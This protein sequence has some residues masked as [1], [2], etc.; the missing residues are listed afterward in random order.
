MSVMKQWQYAVNQ[1]LNATKKNFRKALIL[2]TAHDA[3]LLK[4]MT[5][6][7]GDPDWALLYNRYHPKHIAYRLAYNNWVASGGS[8]SGD[9]LSLTELFK[10][11]PAKLDK[12]IGMIIIVYAKAS[13]QY[14]KLFPQ[15]RK[16][17]EQGKTDVRISAIETLS[18]SIGA[19][20]A[21][22]PVKTLVDAAYVEIDT[23]RTTQGGGKSTK[24]ANSE[25]V[26]EARSAVMIMQY[27]DMGF[28][29]N[30]YPATPNVIVSLFDLQ[31]LRN[32]VQS[33][34]THK[35]KP[36]ENCQLCVNT[37]KATDAIRAKFADAGNLTDQ[38]TIYL[39]STPGGIDSTGIVILNNAEFKFEASQFV[40]DLAT[41]TF[42][43]AVTNGNSDAIM[44]TVELY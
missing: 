3:Y 31:T 29:I 24:K 33:L 44:L 20:V 11:I 28:L 37:F 6:T 26:E 36:T 38:V 34:F 30:K 16:P 43:T 10:L 39:A 4:K 32:N 12:W 7:P 22:A 19:D 18:T 17:F 40:V 5:D 8:L 23:A 15:G 2:S 21:L 25:A 27:A 9:T 1:F 35:M 42:L 14:K 41:H 13:A